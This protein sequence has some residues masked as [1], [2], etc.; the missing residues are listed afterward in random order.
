MKKREIRVIGLLGRVF[1][2]FGLSKHKSDATSFWGRDE[3]RLYLQ[4]RK[5]R[6]A[7]ITKEGKVL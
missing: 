3:E 6:T 4:S 5:N 1:H 2:E 7:L